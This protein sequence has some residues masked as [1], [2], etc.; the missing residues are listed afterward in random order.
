[1]NEASNSE[2]KILLGEKNGLTLHRLIYSIKDPSGK[3]LGT[4]TI[5]HE[6]SYMDERVRSLITWTTLTFAVL[7]FL[8]SAIT[9][10][11][12]RRMFEKS[13]HRLLGWMKSEKDIET[14]PP[15]ESLLKPVTREVE[16]LT[17]RLRSA[18]EGRLATFPRKTGRESLDS[19]PAQSARRYAHGKQ[20]TDRRLESRTLHAREGTGQIKVIV[21]ASGLVASLDPVLKATSGLWIAHG[22]G[23]P[24]W[25][26]ADS[27]SKVLVPPEAPSYTLKRIALLEGGR[28]GLLLRVFERSP[29]AS[30]PSHPSSTSL[31]RKRLDHVRRGKSKICKRNRR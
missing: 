14:P 13:V 25:E 19:R 18:R 31:R 15:T 8:I 29:L 10:F 16:K 11:I 22:A 6:A 5:V 4:L 26:T 17:A 21:P 9:H 1:M 20:K 24:N 12:S 23:D 2:E 7:A 3:F 27:E 28:R 30:L